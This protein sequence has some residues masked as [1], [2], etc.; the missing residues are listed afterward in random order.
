[1]SEG[2]P[3][4]DDLLALIHTATLKDILKK[5]ESGEASPQTLSVA[6]K[7]LKDNNITSDMRTNPIALKLLHE[8]PEDFDDE[9]AA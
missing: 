5:L 2:P 8:L 6:V 1:M 7:L 9:A 4:N 3:S